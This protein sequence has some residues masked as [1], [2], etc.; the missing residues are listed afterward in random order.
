MII[1]SIIRYLQTDDE[2]IINRL[3]RFTK[4]TVASQVE[5]NMITPPKVILDFEYFEDGNGFSLVDRISKWES[6]RLLDADDA[7][8]K[9]V[10]ELKTSV[11]NNKSVVFENFGTFSMNPEGSIVFE[12]DIIKELNGEFYGM[13]PV[14]V[15]KSEKIVTA[16]EI[17]EEIVEVI[18]IQTEIE[19]EPVEIKEEPIEIKEEPIEIEQEPIEIEQERVEIEQERVEIEQEPVEIE[20]EPEIPA[21]VPHIINTTFEESEDKNQADETVDSAEENTGS[22]DSSEELIIKKPKRKS[23]WFERILFIIIILGALALVG[24]LFKKEIKQFYQD[25]FQ[26]TEVVTPTTQP[27]QN[28]QDIASDEMDEISD[29][30]ELVTSEPVVEQPKTVAEQPKTTPDKPKTTTTTGTTTKP[31]QNNQ[32]INQP[33]KTGEY[34]TVSI[35]SGKFYV[36]AGSFVKQQDAIKHIQE[37]KLGSYNPVLVVGQSR[38]RVCIGIFKTEAEATAY[39][40]KIDKTYWVLK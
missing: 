5:G 37:K 10:S 23:R 18:P 14:P 20:E 36:I 3:G 11:Q 9:W 32:P 12:S 24:Y 30:T 6:L 25:H 1:K 28:Q 15:V 33:V 2:L 35:E 13:N 27:I 26:K 21:E 4:R 34:K 8:T 29:T 17:K 39:A 38:V 16:P 40:A 31:I 19:Q 22:E 7:V